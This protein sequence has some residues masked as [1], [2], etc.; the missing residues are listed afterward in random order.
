MAWNLFC[1]LMNGV[2]CFYEIS[3]QFSVFSFQF[4][5]R[6]KDRY[7]VFSY[8]SLFIVHCSLKKVVH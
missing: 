3:S 5:E 7:L 8:C 6:Q 4:S 1:G 2:N